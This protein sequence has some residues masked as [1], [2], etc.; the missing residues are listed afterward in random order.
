MADKKSDASSCG[1]YPAPR[2]WAVPDFVD[3]WGNVKCA[4]CGRVQSNSFTACIWCCNHDTLKFTEDW[5]GTDDCGGWELEVECAVCG[6]NFDFKREEIMRNYI[7]VRR[8]PN[9]RITETGKG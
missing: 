1:S 9:T 6:K 2:C 8:Q 5:H 7:A 3:E 4:K